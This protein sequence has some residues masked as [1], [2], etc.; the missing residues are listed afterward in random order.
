MTH[1]TFDA[2]TIDQLRAGGTLKW[3]AFPDCIGAFVAEMDFGTAPEVMAAV[4]EALD[5]G[6]IG[7]LDNHLVAGLAEA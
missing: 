4:R 7:Y 2:L 6:Q 5:R 3:S 1:S